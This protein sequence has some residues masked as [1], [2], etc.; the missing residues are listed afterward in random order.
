MAERDWRDDCIDAAKAEGLRASRDE[1][2]A[3]LMADARLLCVPGGATDRMADSLAADLEAKAPAPITRAACATLVRAACN[4]R[5]LT[6]TGWTSS[7]ILSV[8]AAAAAKLEMR[9]K[10]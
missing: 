5:G 8:I 3:I 10:P 6:L 7:E 2:D 4:A 9:A 1:P